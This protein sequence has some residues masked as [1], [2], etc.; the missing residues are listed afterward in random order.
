[1]NVFTKWHDNSSSCG[2]I[3]LWT[4]NVNLIGVQKEKSGIPNSFGYIIWEPWIS[5]PNFIPINQLNVVIFHCIQYVK[6]F[7]CCQWHR[8]S[9][10]ITKASSIHPL[11]TMNNCITF[12]GNP[13]N[14]CCD[15]SVKNKNINLIV[16]PE[17]K[18]RISTKTD[19]RIHLVGT[20][21]TF[22]SSWSNVIYISAWTKVVDQPT[23]L[24]PKSTQIK[25]F[26]V[27]LHKSIILYTSDHSRF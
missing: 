19:N 13:S 23:R 1:M 12:N 25:N 22:H 6:T 15:I 20:M 24:T 3:S 8:Q 16:V 11:R 18:V 7:T 17:E 26:W 4:T 2:D 5:V 10:G 21:K 27:G 14:S 9:Q